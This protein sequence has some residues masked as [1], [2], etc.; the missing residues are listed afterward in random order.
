MI[1]ITPI[2]MIV[3]SQFSRVR[4]KLVNFMYVFMYLSILIY[5]P[6]VMR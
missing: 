2:T 1:V 4:N 6:V 3:S 5:L